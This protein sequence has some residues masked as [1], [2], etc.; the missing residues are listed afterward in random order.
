MLLT[1]AG[2]FEAALN[3][4][5]QIS[6]PD[7]ET[8]E[9][10]R[11][12]GV[13]GLRM[14]ILATELPAAQH[15]LADAIG[16]ALFDGY[17]RNEKE[18]EARYVALIVQYPKRAELHYLHGVALL[19]GDTAAAISEFRKEIEIS[20]RHVPARLQIAFEYLSEGE[21]AE[22]RPFAR[23]AVALEPGSF[24]AHNAAGQALLD[25]GDLKG[26]IVEFEKA[27]SLAPD[28]PETHL[29]LAS[30][31][32]QAGRDQDAAREREI[33]AKLRNRVHSAAPQRR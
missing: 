26:G 16:H 18:A 3:R 7:T 33:F 29:K 30:A 32:A 13:A 4:L 5:A 23:Q 15:E 8:P 6:T 17:L 9:L 22:A 19:K 21:P 31:Y 27:R 12:I 1:K 14:P 20:P 11:A 24:V 2:Q 10:I 28:S 25:S